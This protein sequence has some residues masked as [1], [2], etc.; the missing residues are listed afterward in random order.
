M[1]EILDLYAQDEDPLRPVVCFDECPYQLISEL[2]VPHPAKLGRRA[3]YDYEY[4][5]EGTCNLFV[6]FV[7]QKGWRHIK[8]TDR[9]TKEDFA[10]CMKDLV[11]IHLPKADK[12]RVVLD[13][14]NTHTMR[15]LY[16]TFEPEEARRIRRKIQFYYTPIHAS[17]LNMVEIELAVL[18][19]QCLNR[20]IANRNL[21]ERELAVWQE[22]RNRQKTTV[23]WAFT[24]EKAQTKLK[25]F[26][27][28]NS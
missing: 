16:E 5:R 18:S 20:R 6:F 24:S 15:A 13:N 26:Y 2:R 19:G 14:L 3:R 10:F 7:H 28:A 12:I 4:R 1:E 22:K 17:W 9:R 25:R 23:E 27:C 8:V 11:D 21:L